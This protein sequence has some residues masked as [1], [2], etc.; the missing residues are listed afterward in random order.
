MPMRGSLL[1]QIVKPAGKT[2]LLCAEG[3]ESQSLAG[4]DDGERAYHV[5]VFV[6]YA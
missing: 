1:P 5:R 6:K 4:C 2:M 3:E